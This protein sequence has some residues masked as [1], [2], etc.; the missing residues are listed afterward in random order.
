MADRNLRVVEPIEPVEGNPIEMMADCKLSPSEGKFCLA[1]LAGN[2]QVDGLNAGWPKS[3]NW[4]RNVQ[5]VKACVIAARPHVQQFM[6]LA[7]LAGA[8]QSA[9]TYAT[10]LQDLAAARQAATDAG[11]HN[12]AIRSF[13]VEG[14]VRGWINNGRGAAAL[15]EG[16][17]L[18]PGEM[19]IQVK[20]RFGI[21]AARRTA[22]DLGQ[23][24]VA[25]ELETEMRDITPAGEIDH[26]D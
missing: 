23:F 22:I 4:K 16:E 12:A 7:R 14:R 20:A 15:D 17:K 26:D 13:E 5:H 18:A 24:D 6:R 9:R 11:Q 19:V 2:S 21:E 10:Y 25:Q 8:Q 3:K 1:I